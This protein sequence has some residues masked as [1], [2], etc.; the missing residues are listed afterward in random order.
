MVSA[1][2]TGGTGG[3]STV[4]SFLGFGGG[5]GGSATLSSGGL[6]PAVFGSSARGGAVT[7]FAALNI[8]DG[9]VIGRNMQRHR[10]QEPY[11]RLSL[12]QM[13]WRLRYQQREG[14]RNLQ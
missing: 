7:L 10:H 2:A 12:W 13:N 6:G 4:S 11:C 9:T 5:N 1:V 14:E 3:G 8:L